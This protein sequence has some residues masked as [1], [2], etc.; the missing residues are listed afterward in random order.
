MSELNLY[1]KLCLWI[2]RHYFCRVMDIIKGETFSK[3]LISLLEMRHIEDVIT[4][5]NSDNLPGL[6]MKKANVIY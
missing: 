2:K 6:T 1:V 4:I 3:I 5:H